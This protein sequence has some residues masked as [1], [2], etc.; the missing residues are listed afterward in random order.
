MNNRQK[1]VISIA[2]LGMGVTFL[3]PRWARL[4]FHDTGQG[5][6][7]LTVLERRLFNNP[8]EAS[9]V[10]APYIAWRYSLQDSIA[11]AVAASVLCFVL[12]T[13]KAHKGLASNEGPSPAAAF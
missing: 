5:P 7:L 11:A 8:P 9:E 2:L 10:K 1:L 12:R 13:K 3:F 4:E 6:V